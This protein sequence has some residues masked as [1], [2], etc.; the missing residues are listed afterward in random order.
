MH[1][2]SFK[3]F[4]I[5]IG[6]VF[7]QVL[8][9]NCTLQKRVHRKGYHVAWNHKHSSEHKKQPNLEA[10]ELAST[11]K[12][13][14]E[15]VIVSANPSHQMDLGSLKRKPLLVLN[16]D[17]CGDV[18]LLQNADELRVKV[19]E[20][21]DQ[22]IKYKRCDNL[23]GPTYSISKSKVA[24]I[25]YANGMKEKVTQEPAYRTSDKNQAPKTE[26]PRKVNLLGL[27]SLLLYVFGVILSRGM[28]GVL[29]TGS[30]GVLL[31][32]LSVAPLVMAYIALFQFKREP[33]KYKG[34]W[35]PVT[36]VCMYLAA[37]LLIA[38][39]LAAFAATMSGAVGAVVIL[40]L[41]LFLLFLGILIAA[42]VPKAK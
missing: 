1:K 34:R 37:L 30:I 12:V 4:K 9:T 31:L 24:M 6:L 20:I 11:D 21:D 5:L 14:S 19:L 41:L 26:M 35:M 32:I 22:I 18:L 39:V 8:F 25:T 38:L 2:L 16:P 3:L 29:L 40:C 15:D 27:S 23:T 13:V 33:D 17:T 42:L 7:M 36:V 10:K 28:S